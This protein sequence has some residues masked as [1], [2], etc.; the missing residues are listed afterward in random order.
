MS[1][2]INLKLNQKELKMLINNILEII[3]LISVT[4]SYVWYL[5]KQSINCIFNNVSTYLL[6]AKY[7]PKKL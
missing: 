2:I 3:F 7:F 6:I 5:F 4:V 1:K